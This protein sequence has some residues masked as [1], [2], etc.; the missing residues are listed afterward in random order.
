MIPGTPTTQ[1][2]S[3]DSRPVLVRAAD[4]E[5]LGVTLTTIQLPADGDP[6]SEAVSAQQDRQGYGRAPRYHTG[7][8]E[9]F[10][11]IEGGHHVL[12]G[13]RSS[14]SGKATS[15]WCHGT[16]RMPSAHPGDTGV[17]MLFLMPG[18][19]RFEDFRLGD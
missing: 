1:L 15:S 10:F 9:I 6:A 14:P 13:E 4:A 17:D 16:P 7:S 11:I 18:A 5:I 19:E 3:G 8:A 2:T 12:A